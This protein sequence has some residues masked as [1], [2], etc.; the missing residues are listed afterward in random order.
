MI[1]SLM[2]LIA[3]LSTPEDST[4]NRAVRVSGERAA[5]GSLSLVEKD[6]GRLD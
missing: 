6:L 2:I 5:W 1:W 3:R 4:V